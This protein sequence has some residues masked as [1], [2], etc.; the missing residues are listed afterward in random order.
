M[1]PYLSRPI[2]LD[3]SSEHSLPLGKT[4][5]LLEETV[6]LPN[7]M[8]QHLVYDDWFQHPVFWFFVFLFF[9]KEAIWY[10]KEDT[11][12]DLEVFSEDWKAVEGEIRAELRP[13]RR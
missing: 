1:E 6:S 4:W 7:Y 8:E 10:V 5:F 2:K 9:W 13:L 12:K 11:I 3:E